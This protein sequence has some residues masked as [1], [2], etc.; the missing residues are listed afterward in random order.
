MDFLLKAAVSRCVAVI[1]LC[2]ISSNYLVLLTVCKNKRLRHPVCCFL[3][4]L[5]LADLFVGIF[6]IPVSIVG[7]LLQTAWFY[8]RLFDLLIT[9]SFTAST[10]SLCA[11]TY[12]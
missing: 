3:A 9:Q 2:I 6:T 8:S 11:L 12:D 5:S 4:S 10:F 7:F 1:S